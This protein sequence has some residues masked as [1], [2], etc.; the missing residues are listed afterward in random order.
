M[1]TLELG[2]GVQATVGSGF[3]SNI[4]SLHTWHS[5]C[6]WAL[7]IVSSKLMPIYHLPRAPIFLQVR[8]K[9]KNQ[10]VSLMN[11][12]CQSLDDGHGGF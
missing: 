1:G 7:F 10:M 2:G 9:S 3:C 5:G 8:E 6:L 4:G 11:N 12:F